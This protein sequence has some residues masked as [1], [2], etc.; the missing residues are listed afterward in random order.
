M[1][2]RPPQQSW[3]E[4]LVSPDNVATILAA[5]LAAIL[6]ASV[7]M[8]RYQKQKRTDR[9]D[10]MADVY[11]HALQAVQDYIEAPYMVLRREDTP[12]GN[13]GVSRRISEIQSRV[14]F[15]RAWMDIRAPGEVRE[16]FDTLVRTV[17]REVGPQI[18]EA[19]RAPARE[20]GSDIPLGEKPDTSASDSA[21][22][23]VADA[24]RADL[25]G[26]P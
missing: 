14:D 23:A 11:A 2:G 21:M 15:S 26:E 3:L 18:T 16:L 12:A 24:M 1:N 19:W 5:L 13:A 25:N 7:A 17:R 22:A 9:Q 6:A 8:S 20:T 4:Q 10:R